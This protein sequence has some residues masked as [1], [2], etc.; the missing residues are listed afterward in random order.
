MAQSRHDIHITFLRDHY[1]LQEANHR[2]H[3]TQASCQSN[4]TDGS[5]TRT[6]HE[7][8]TKKTLQSD[9]DVQ[10]IPHREPMA[11]ATTFDERVEGLEQGV[12]GRHAKQQQVL[13]VHETPSVEEVDVAVQAQTTQELADVWLEA[14]QGPDPVRPG[15]GLA[16]EGEA[17]NQHK[18]RTT[19][20]DERRLTQSQRTWTVVVTRVGLAGCR[21]E[22]AG[23]EIGQ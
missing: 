21:E 19:K 20:K 9:D 22:R 11:T 5:D 3:K 15:H 10:R 12:R 2:A 6:K 8:S 7:T 4:H 18:G 14:G 13:K 17:G 16:S 23:Q 1:L